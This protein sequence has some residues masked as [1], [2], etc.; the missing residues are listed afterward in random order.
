MSHEENVSVIC[1]TY[2]TGDVLWESID[3]ILR[4]KELYELIIVN[5]GNE[6][7]VISKLKQLSKNNKKVK[8]LLNDK[9]IG[10]AAGCNLGVSHAQGEYILLMN[11]D[12]IIL[13]NSNFH[14][15][16]FELELNPEIYLATGTILNPDLTPQTTNVRN[17]LTPFMALTESMPILYKS[18]LFK[19]L[20]IKAPKEKSI[21]PACSGAFMFMKKE[22]FEKLDK[23]D[24]KYFFHFEDMDL[25]FKINKIGGKILFLPY[26]KIVHHK[27]S[28]EV[29]GYFVE[30]NKTKGFIRYY[31]KNF[32]QRLFLKL[33]LNL[34]LY[35][36]LVLKCLLNTTDYL[37]SIKKKTFYII[38]GIS[39]IISIIADSFINKHTAF[40]IENSRFFYAWYGFFSC[41]TIIFI[42]K[43]FAFFVK[44]N[45]N[46]YN[47]ENDE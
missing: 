44:R 29:S 43:I 24:A 5:N 4:Q 10:F 1:V 20:N 3:S 45:E 47:L 7:H 12:C 22:I 35:F 32:E 21:I 40:T 41:V 27:S 26:V 11:P 17:I 13:G 18:G 34:V 16:I 25:C 28:S 23:I 2:F 33:I 14:Q 31:T 46:Y 42:S 38:L 39:S 6:P 37:F 15:L 8:L 9:N 36:R 19:R 30:L